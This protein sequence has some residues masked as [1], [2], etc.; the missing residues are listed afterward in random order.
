MGKNQFRARLDAGSEDAEAYTRFDKTAA[1]L[2]AN[3]GGLISIY[4][5]PTEFVNTEFWDGVNFAG[6]ANPPRAE[7]KAP[8]KRT[9]QDSERCYNVL[10]KFVEHMKAVPDIRFITAADLLRIYKNPPS[11]TVERSLIAQHLRKGI[12]YLSTDHA[13][14][15]P[16]DMVLQLLGVDPQFVDGP[17]ARGVTTWKSSAIPRAAFD[18]AARDAADFIRHNHR[19][20]NQVFIGAETLSLAD[21]VAT[22]AASDTITNPVQLTRGSLKFEEHFSNDPVKSFSWP[23]HPAG[24]AAPELLELG[25]LQGWTM[26]PARL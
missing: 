5:H 8:R 6:G 3:G 25:K 9:K 17:T 26:K 15:S 24:F 14:L 21:F 23:I 4:Y 11:P 18:A 12:D 20:P 2:R 16:A 19:L 7:W 1:E 22:L 10:R 13:I